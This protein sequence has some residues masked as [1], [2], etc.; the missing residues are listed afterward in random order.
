MFYNSEEEE[1]AHCSSDFIT[2]DVPGKKVEL[3]VNITK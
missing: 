2:V 1:A 3:P